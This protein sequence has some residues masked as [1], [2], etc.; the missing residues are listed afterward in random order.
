MVQPGPGSLGARI[1]K[2]RIEKGLS[3]KDLAEA[4]GIPA[5]QTISMIEKGRREVK[6][7][8]LQLLASALNYDLEAMLA[9]EPE[10]AG[11]PAILWRSPTGR[12]THV[13]SRRARLEA[14]FARKLLDYAR[15]EKLCGLEPALWLDEFSWDWKNPSPL[16]AEKL[17]R[18]VT[19]A[20]SPGAR[21]AFTLARLLEEEL[22]I[23]IWYDDIGS[24]GRAACTRGPSG[25]G[26]L[27]NALEAPWRRNFNVARELFHLIAWPADAPRDVSPAQIDRLAN[28]FASSLLLPHTEFDR[29]LSRRKAGARLNFE[30]LFQLARDFGVAAESVL[31]RL[32][33]LRRMG[34][35]DVERLL[36]DSHLRAIDRNT[37]GATWLRAPRY[38][39]RFVRLCFFAWRRGGLSR[40]ALAS[41][42]D[43]APA[44]VRGIL[45]SYGFDDQEDYGTPVS[46]P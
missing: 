36:R 25:Y 45:L 3:Q 18:N 23:K 11:E 27:I 1:Q 12:R 6:A 22:L 30:D 9:P 32:E 21:P 38:P 40:P 15:S 41:M 24:V 39:E 8:E 37:V 16:Q 44:E 42:L 17:A 4:C 43:V 29:L 34:S 5:H 31:W 13:R 33:G 20:L 26:M 7:A 10:E 28:T 2:L 19:E 46:G 35:G 14:H